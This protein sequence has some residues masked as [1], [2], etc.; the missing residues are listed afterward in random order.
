MTSSAHIAL[1]YSVSI[2]PWAH[3]KLVRQIV[4]TV[5]STESKSNNAASLVKLAKAAE[6]MAEFLPIKPTESFVTLRH[7]T[8][9]LGERLGERARERTL[10]RLNAARWS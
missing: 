7:R 9:K 3:A 1:R 5:T 6:V 2:R 10:Q 8:L 4:L